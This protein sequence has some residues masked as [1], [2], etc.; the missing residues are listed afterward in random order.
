MSEKE[1][2]DAATVK[3]I[4]KNA[5]QFHICEGC[6]SVIRKKYSVC[7]IC[8]SYRFNGDEQT[9]RDQVAFIFNTKEV[10]PF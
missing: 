6:F 7:S 2:Q 10:S 1:K 4:T 3:S 8:K 5:H 9:V